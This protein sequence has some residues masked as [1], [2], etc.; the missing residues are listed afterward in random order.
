MNG[1]NDA[2]AARAQS[3]QALAAENAAAAQ[4]TQAAAGGAVYENESGGQTPAAAVQSAETAAGEQKAARSAKKAILQ[5][6]KFL[7]FSLSAGAIQLVSFEL[8]YNWTGWLPWWPSYLIGISLSVLW[9]FTFNRKFTFASAGNVPL[10][11]VLA[12]LFYVAFVPASLFGGDA[13]EAGGWN[14]TLVTLMMMVINFVGEFFWDK[15]VVFND[16]L[17]QKLFPRLHKK[18]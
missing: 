11:M 9:N 6:L 14:G 12:A 10:A 5:F 7:C 18:K 15:F 17:L 3:A 13:L 4:N 16:A 2:P 1:Q 8:L